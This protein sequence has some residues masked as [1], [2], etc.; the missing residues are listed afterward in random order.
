MKHLSNGTSNANL[1][2][3]WLLNCL[4]ESRNGCGPYEKLDNNRCTNLFFC[5]IFA[6]EASF[7]KLRTLEFKMAPRAM[8]FKKWVKTYCL[9]FPLSIFLLINQIL[10]FFTKYFSEFL[11][12]PLPVAILKS[13]YGWPFSHLVLSKILLGEKTTMVILV[14]HIWP[15]VRYFPDFYM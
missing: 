11:G 8:Y 12:P 5:S 14:P 3:K 1:S 9:I 10:K 4:E 6:C 15:F 13:T 7:K 2:R